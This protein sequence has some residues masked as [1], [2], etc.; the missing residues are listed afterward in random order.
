MCQ[1]R[2]WGLGGQDAVGGRVK[3]IRK[4]LLWYNKKRRDSM[5]TT[6]HSRACTWAGPTTQRIEHTLALPNGR[7]LQLTSSGRSHSL[8]VTLLGSAET[9]TGGVPEVLLA[10]R[11]VNGSM[12]HQ[13]VDREVAVK[14]Y[15]V[16]VRSFGRSHCVHIA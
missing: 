11:Q 10:S 6:L 16:R 4:A 2:K 14:G 12:P 5:T 1:R 9:E 13:A 7:S 8:I 15:R 3:E